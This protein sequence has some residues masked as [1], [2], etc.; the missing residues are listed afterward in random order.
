M[1]LPAGGGTAWLTGACAPW[2]CALYLHVQVGEVELSLSADHAAPVLAALS[3]LLASAATDQ[4][5]TR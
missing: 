3:A 5:V 4:E 2:R 1:G